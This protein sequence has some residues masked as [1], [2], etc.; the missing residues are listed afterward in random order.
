MRCR[1]DLITPCFASLL[2]ERLTISRFAPMDPAISAWVG[3]FFDD[4]T[5]FQLVVLS[6]KAQ[7]V[8]SHALF[9]GQR[10]HFHVA[11]SQAADAAHKLARDAVTYQWDVVKEL[12]K[13]VPFDNQ[14]PCICLGDNRER[15]GRAIESGQFAKKRADMKAR[16]HDFAA[17]GGPENREQCA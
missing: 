1:A 15:S 6:S 7:Q 10:R 3:A 17:F 13:A 11:L 2:I 16:K 12:Q 4:S 5:C 14:H 9:D 8:S